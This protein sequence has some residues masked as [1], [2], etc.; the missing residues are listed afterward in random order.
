SFRLI[1]LETPVLEFPETSYLCQSDVGIFLGPA[2]PN[3][4]FSYAWDSGET[5]PNLEVAQAGEYTLTATNTEGGLSC[6]DTR[7]VTVIA[8]EPPTITDIEIEDLSNNNI[9]TVMA[10]GV[11]ALE[12]RLDD[13]DYRTGNVFQNVAPGRHTVTVNDPQGCGAVSEEVLVIG[14]PKF[15]TPN[16]DGMNDVWHISGLELLQDPS[17]AIFDRYGKLMVKLD[18][19]SDDWMGTFRGRL[20]PESDYWFR[21][22]YTDDNGQTVTAKYIDNH[23]SLKR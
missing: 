8:S 1:N 3:P 14:F 20:L 10:N 17:V 16:N 4:N 11:N 2:N 7:T 23:F 21:L 22:T 5:I 19:S 13:G 9:I 15:F 12:Y 18:G 6:S